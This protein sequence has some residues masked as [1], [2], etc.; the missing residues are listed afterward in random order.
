MH[1]G[2]KYMSLVTRPNS[3]TLG[4]PV[5]VYHDFSESDV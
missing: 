2:I 4:K 5:F 1:N 3:V